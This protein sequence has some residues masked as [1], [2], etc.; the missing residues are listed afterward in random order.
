MDPDDSEAVADRFLDL[1]LAQTCPLP[2]VAVL[3]QEYQSPNAYANA[4]VTDLFA[5]LPQISG[6]GHPASGVIAGGETVG[7]PGSI[8]SNGD[9]GEVKDEGGNGNEEVTGTSEDF[10]TV[11]NACKWM[12]LVGRLVGGGKL[13]AEGGKDEQVLRELL[14]EGGEGKEWEGMEGRN[15]WETV[16]GKMDDGLIIG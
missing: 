3:E 14:G 7:E 12:V 4:L 5:P 10:W 8:G 1:L 2:S 13:V 9:G 6:A 16:S 15:V 11:G